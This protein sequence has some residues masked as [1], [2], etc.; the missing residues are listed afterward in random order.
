MTDLNKNT[1]NKTVRSNSRVAGGDGMNVSRVGQSVAIGPSERRAAIP[2]AGSGIFAV[3][4]VEEFDNWVTAYRYNWSTEEE[5][6]TLLYVAKAPHLRR[7][8][9]ENGGN[10]VEYPGG[11]AVPTVLYE[12][13]SSNTR[14]A[15]D[16]TETWSVY[17]ED[18]QITPSYYVG[19]IFYVFTAQ[20]GLE[21]DEVEP[22][23][24]TL[25]DM[26]PRMW[27]RITS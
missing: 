22:K 9:Y 27:G 11:I 13:I 18:Q 15:T 19:E 12:Y 4:V 5:G 25:V 24:I 14:K 20:T 8:I 2:A 16:Q 7:D 21:T 1:W 26:T 23:K 3:S 6:E 17:Y 10:P